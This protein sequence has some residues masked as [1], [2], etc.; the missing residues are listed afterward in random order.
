MDH[1]LEKKLYHKKEGEEKDKE[2]KVDCSSCMSPSSSSSS[3]AKFEKQALNV[4]FYMD[5]AVIEGE[6][7][8]NHPPPPA[9]QCRRD[10]EMT[11]VLI[12]SSSVEDI[13]HDQSREKNKV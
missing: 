13:T 7:T 12:W 5:F 6:K 3:S 4:K 10:R 9:S 8:K 2:E 11:C 1:S